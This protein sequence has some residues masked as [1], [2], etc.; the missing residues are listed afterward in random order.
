M[1]KKAL[2]AEIPAIYNVTMTLADTEYSQA[3]PSACKK[4]L[5]QVR[6]GTA[7][8]LAFVT[9]KVATLT[10]PYL[11]IAAN[12]I[13]NEDLIGPIA[14]TLY[15]GCDVASKVVEIVAWS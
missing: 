10:E 8:R 11:T 4:F 9:G 12:C 1:A 7:F 6:D 3:L 5:I 14:L 13:Y 15:F 2:R